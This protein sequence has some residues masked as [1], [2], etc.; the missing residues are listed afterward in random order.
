MMILLLQGV[1][2]SHASRHTDRNFSPTFICVALTYGAKN[3]PRSV[4]HENQTL[5]GPKFNCSPL[6]CCDIVERKHAETKTRTFDGSA[7]TLAVANFADLLR[8][9]IYPA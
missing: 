5:H 2:L 4:C 8:E 1:I 7:L 9:R 6:T 3:V